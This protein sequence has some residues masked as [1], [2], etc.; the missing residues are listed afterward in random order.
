MDTMKR[1]FLIILFLSFSVNC[2]P[3]TQKI[4]GDLLITSGNILPSGNLTTSLNYYN[5]GVTD[6]RWV[7]IYASSANISNNFN[8]FG[9]SNIA[10]LNV[11]T[12]LKSELL[13]V[14]NVR[15]DANTISSTSGTL[16]IN[17]VAGSSAIIDGHWGF[18]STTMTAQ[19]DANT[20]I[21]AYSGKNISIEGSTFD[22]GILT[23]PTINA[24]T[25]FQTNGTD[26]NTAGALSNVAYLNQANQFSLNQNLVKAVTAQTSFF[27]S[28]DP[29]FSIVNSGSGL[30]GSVTFGKGTYDSPTAMGVI[31][32]LNSGTSPSGAADAHFM[33]NS[34]FIQIK[35]L[36]GITVG[37]TNRDLYVDDWH[38]IGYVSS[39]IRYKK[40]INSL[41]S[42]SE[43][44][45]GLHPVS[46]RY[47]KDNSLDFGLIAEEV[48]GS[49]P[50]LV[51][52]NLDEE[53]NPTIPETVSYS[54][55]TPLLLNEFIKAKKIID[56]L[57]IR[58]KYLEDSH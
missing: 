14:N 51:S 33:L 25:V 34:S 16:N 6:N 10:S 48:E 19:T 15:I 57:E 3:M 9:E 42:Y 26:I 12:A 52:Y 23:C 30:A 40:D 50:E 17:P 54:K 22:G 27:E 49:L 47:K 35:P 36:Y 21:T 38:N 44:I 45:Y 29:Y 56:Q 53:G 46:F 8:S 2:H 55:I 41:D 37:G 39:S 24:T 5:I 11:G 28:V 32:V 1:L 58:I 7:N 18:D 13:D 43:K 4:T 31:R 20:T